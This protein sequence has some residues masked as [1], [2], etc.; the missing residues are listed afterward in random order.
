[1]IQVIDDKAK[2]GRIDSK[3]KSNKYYE[4]CDQNGHTWKYCW[5]VQANVKKAKRL[6][7]ID[8][9]DDGPSDPFHSIG[10]EV[11]F[12]MMILK[13]LSEISLK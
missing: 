7:E 5:E 4:Y 3:Q 9:R 12:L 13:T 11:Q 8:D 1:M 6:K 2:N 10:S